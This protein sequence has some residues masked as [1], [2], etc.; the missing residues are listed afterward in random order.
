V[1]QAWDVLAGR[2]VTGN[3]VVVIG[4]GAVGVEVSLF[5]AEKGTL[6]PEAVKFLL[7]NRAAPP[8]E[9][10]R[11]ATRGTKTVTLVEMLGKIG[12]DIGKSTRWTLLQEMERVGINSGVDTRALEITPAGV[13]VAAGDG[14]ASLIPADTVVM[15]AGSAPHNPL[16]DALEKSA[17]AFQVVGDAGGVGLAFD[18]VHQGFDAGRAV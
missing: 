17:I 13:R 3:R 9:L 2:A 7:V 1:V 14:A 8:D 12:K 4:G 5:L 10:Y 15:A 18:A 11:L 6:S 16:K